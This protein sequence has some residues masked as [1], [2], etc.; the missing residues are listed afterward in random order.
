MR[1]LG[2]T[3]VIVLAASIAAV[4]A[5]GSA[6]RKQPQLRVV[7]LAPVTVKGRGF[8]ARERVRVVAALEEQ[9]RTRTVRAST[10]GTFTA[11]FETLSA[12]R[13]SAGG[14]VEAIGALGS[15]GDAKIPR[16]PECPPPP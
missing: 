6:A 12:H 15:R 14:T 5:T 11:T 7:D 4:G 16:Q 8:R 2:L 10:L 3:A 13:C 9:R 1:V